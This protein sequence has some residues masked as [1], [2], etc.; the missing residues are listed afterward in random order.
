MKYKLYRMVDGEWYYWG[1]YTD[2]ASLAESAFFLGQS[3][4]VTQIKVEA[5]SVDA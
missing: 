5:V 1:T 2:P 3:S 4:D